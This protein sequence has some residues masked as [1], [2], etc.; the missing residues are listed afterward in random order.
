MDTTERVTGLLQR[1]GAGDAAALD[2]AF[3]LVYDHL[4]RL[5]HR[6]LLLED[7]GH[8]LDTTALV[9][10]AYLRLVDQRRGQYRDRT[11]FLAIAAIAMR[12]ILV[13]HARR[14]TAAK[15]GGGARRISLDQ[16]GDLATGDRADV[17]VALDDAL[18]RLATLDARQARVVEC[19]FF[20]GLTEEETADVLAIS[21]R[22]V[23]R[24]WT[25]AR[26]WLANELEP[27]AGA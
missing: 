26:A 11:H 24:D 17:L 4:R 21:T 18:G 19:R 23:K 15:R 25:K 27:E 20:G 3:P 7:T 12:R 8:T 2:E 10:E 6:E 1:A 14:Q 22:T 16:A 9:H 13:D 5:A